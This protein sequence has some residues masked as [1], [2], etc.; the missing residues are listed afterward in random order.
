M[1]RNIIWILLIMAS[2]WPALLHAQPL[3]PAD[4]LRIIKTTAY[5]NKRVAYLDSIK[6]LDEP[7][8]KALT[9]SFY[10][11]MLVDSNYS[12]NFNKAMKI[13]VTDTLYYIAIAQDKLRKAALT[14]CDKALKD[15]ADKYKLTADVIEKIRPYQYAEKL[16]VG[17]LNAR[18]KGE[19][20]LKDSLKQPIY[21]TLNDNINVILMRYG[22]KK[23]SN[24]ITSA[25]VNATLLQLSEEQK[26]SL[27][28]CQVRL[29]QL[30]HAFVGKDVLERF[31][32]RPFII[33]HLP[34]ILSPE[35][36]YKQLVFEA[37]V[38]AYRDTQHNWDELRTYKLTEN[39]DSVA[40]DKM[41]MEYNLT[42]VMT[43][44]LKGDEGKQLPPDYKAKMPTPGAL[45]LPE[46]LH[47][48]AIA[49]KM[50]YNDP[51]KH[52]LTW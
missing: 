42:R 32:Q 48:L 10:Q 31:D 44:W 29:S 6:P 38:P 19:S 27:Q 3:V 33:A 15:L 46:L 50:G 37:Q 23:P 41:L 25:L 16:A 2:A 14:G 1:K 40:T 9:D 45:I 52:T 26:D 34:L 47:K 28:A 4:S 7:M 12:K 13:T 30:A 22:Y 20:P 35:Q 11:F 17:E 18:M 5:F 43:I 24:R 51:S 36:Y 39:L 49:K 21:D 8:R